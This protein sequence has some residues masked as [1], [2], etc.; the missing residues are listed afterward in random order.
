M[1]LKLDMSKAYDQLECPFVLEVLS[2]VGFPIHLVNLI[3][4]CISLVSYKFLINDQ[5]NNGFTERG[6]CQGDKLSPCLFI[7]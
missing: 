2:S 5:L 1:A 7:L 3:G 6:L 4:R